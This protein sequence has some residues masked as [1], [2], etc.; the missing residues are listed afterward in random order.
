M[1]NQNQFYTYV[2]LDPRKSG[3]F[4]YQRGID[5]VYCFN[6]E[7]IYTGKGSD[8]RIDKHI[9]KALNTNKNKLFYNVIRK[10]YDAG[11]EPIR[12]KILQNATEEEAF[13]EEINLISIAG[14]RD[15][16]K[17]PLCNE[18][19]GGEGASGIKIEEL[20]G[21]KFGKLTVLNY[22]SKDLCGKSKWLCKCG[23]GNKKVI[24]SSSLKDGKTKSCGCLHKNITKTHGM[25]KHCL[26]DIWRGMFRTCK[27]NKNIIICERWYDI[28]N[29][30]DDVGN[31]PSKNYIL[32]R[33][34]IDDNFN[35]STCRWLTKKEQANNKINNNR[36]NIDGQ[37]KTIQEW[38][39][40]SGT[41]YSSIHY[42]LTYSNWSPKEAVFGKKK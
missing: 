37:L 2:Y 10:I 26:Y 16:G 3:D 33:I 34:N 23:C 42:R 19:D 5:E 38:S 1:S 17:G 20:S 29:F 27:R 35:P 22:H 13:A 28:K 40:I 24:V 6:Y 21:Q 15:L 8:G 18:T 7:L 25:K 39:E 41:K 30:I 32:G 4:I 31:R 9:Y 36:I 11:L 14:R 12:I